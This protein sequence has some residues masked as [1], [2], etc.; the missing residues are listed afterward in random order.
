[1][2]SAAAFQLWTM[3]WRFLLTMASSEEATIAA[4][5]SCNSS[6]EP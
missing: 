3:P 1:M 4:N 5:R 2:R 6:G